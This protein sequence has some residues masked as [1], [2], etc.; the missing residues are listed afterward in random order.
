MRDG[1]SL[2]EKTYSEMQMIAAHTGA[3]AYLPAYLD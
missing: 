1:V 2:N 3:E